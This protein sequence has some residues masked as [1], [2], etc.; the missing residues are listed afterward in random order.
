MSVDNRHFSSLMWVGTRKCQFQ[1]FFFQM[2]SSEIKRLFTFSEG[3]CDISISMSFPE[4][5]N[6]AFQY[7]LDGNRAFLNLVVKFPVL[8]MEIRIFFST[9]A[10]LHRCSQGHTLRQMILAQCPSI[11]FP[12]SLLTH[13]LTLP[14]RHRGLL[15]LT[16]TIYIQG[17]PVNST[18]GCIAYAQCLKLVA[19]F[20][21]L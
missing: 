13:P 16:G 6:Y 1:R 10:Y 14:F 7:T 11:V 18:R 17:E 5:I 9:C 21:P 12:E 20:S 19:Q 15:F 8:V 2:H 3:N 4:T